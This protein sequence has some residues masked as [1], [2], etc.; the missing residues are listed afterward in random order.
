MEEKQAFF[1]SAG[2]VEDEDELMNEL[3]ELEAEMAAEDFEGVDIAV[4]SVAPV[5]AP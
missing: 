1:V 5:H 2:K 4:G 3:D